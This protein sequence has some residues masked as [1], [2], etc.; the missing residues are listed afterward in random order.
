MSFDLAAYIKRLASFSRKTFGPGF[1]HGRIVNHIR[2]EL[3][4]IEA[5]PD[6]LTEWID[7]I[8]LAVDGATRAGY[9]AE[10]IVSRLDGKLTVVEGREWPD[11][12]TVPEGV[13]IEHVRS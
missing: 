4:E 2:K 6:D 8:I 10:E 5:A 7:V 1:N 11:W 12:R 3:V 13:P 9:S